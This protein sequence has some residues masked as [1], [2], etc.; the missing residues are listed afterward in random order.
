MIGDD[1]G[2]IKLWKVPTGTDQK[3]LIAARRNGIVRVT[4]HFNANDDLEALNDFH[5]VEETE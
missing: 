2:L 4:R 3:I 1:N 5:D